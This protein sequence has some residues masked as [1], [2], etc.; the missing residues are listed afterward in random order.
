MKADWDKEIWVWFGEEILEQEKP[1]PELNRSCNA[2]REPDRTIPSRSVPESS[3]AV[4]EI[5]EETGI[6]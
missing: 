2:E 4:T 3:F 1:C 5:A 6:T